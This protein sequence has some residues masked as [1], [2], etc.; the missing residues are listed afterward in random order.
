MRRFFGFGFGF[1]EQGE[2]YRVNAVHFLF[3]LKRCIYRLVCCVM[4]LVKVFFSYGRSSVSLAY[5]AAHK[6]V[7]SDNFDLMDQTKKYE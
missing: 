6:M 2:T 3:S 4:E 7:E 1:W 5:S